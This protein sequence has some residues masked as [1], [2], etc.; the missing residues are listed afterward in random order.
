M[1]EALPEHPAGLIIASPANPTG[2]MLAPGDLAA[3]AR[4]CHEQRH[5]A[6]LG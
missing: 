3:L 5:P 2:S 1:L 4:Y 6:D